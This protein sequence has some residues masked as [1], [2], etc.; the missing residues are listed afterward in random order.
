MSLLLIL[1]LPL[2]ACLIGAAVGL[3]ARENPPQ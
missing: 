1:A 3:L 2:A